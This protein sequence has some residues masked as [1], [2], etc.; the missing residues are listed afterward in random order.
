MAT[1]EKYMRDPLTIRQIQF[2]IRRVLKRIK[3]GA[4]PGEIVELYKRFTPEQLA[5]FWT[6]FIGSMRGLKGFDVRQW[7]KFFAECLTEAELQGYINHEPIL[8]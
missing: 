6:G 7:R 4:A 8:N 3:A 1:Q 2:V 5:F